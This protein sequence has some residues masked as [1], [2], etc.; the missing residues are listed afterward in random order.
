MSNYKCCRCRFKTVEI[1][2][3]GHGSE[4]S[5]PKYGLENIGSG[6]ENTKMARKIPEDRDPTQKNRDLTGSGYETLL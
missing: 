3:F 4:N 6:Y 1:R 2:S 5:V